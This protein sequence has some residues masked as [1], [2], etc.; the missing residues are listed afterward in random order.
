MARGFLNLLKEGERGLGQP[1]RG[2]TGAFAQSALNNPHAVEG[3]H[4]DS[5]SCDLG[6]GTLW[7]NRAEGLV[8]VW[9]IEGHRGG[10]RL[11]GGRGHG[12]CLPYRGYR[13]YRLL[14]VWKF[15]GGGW[16]CRVLR[17]RGSGG[18]GQRG[19]RRLG[20]P[21][22]EPCPGGGLSGQPGRRTGQHPE[23]SWL[24]AAPTPPEAFGKQGLRQRRPGLEAACSWP[25]WALAPA[26]PHVPIPCPLQTQAE[27][28]PSSMEADGPQGPSRPGRLIEAAASHPPETRSGRVGGLTWSHR[29]EGFL[30]VTFPSFLPSSNNQEQALMGGTWGPA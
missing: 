18:E 17:G 1:D 4:Q 29:P 3:K 8:C 24:W 23:C 30:V 15:G 5:L 21:L 27:K 7:G 14:S 22:Q 9:H 6:R 26:L 19:P 25:A 13:G 10:R 2:P 20:G 11:W 16:S 12:L 28:H